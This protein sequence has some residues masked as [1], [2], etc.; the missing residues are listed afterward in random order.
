MLRSSLLAVSAI[1]VAAL[2]YHLAIAI[3]GYMIFSTRMRL[4]DGRLAGFAKSRVY[5]GG[6]KALRLVDLQD[7]V[8]GPLERAVLRLPFGRR[9]LLELAASKI[10]VKIEIALRLISSICTISFFAGWLFLG[11]LVSGVTLSLGVAVGIRAWLKRKEA[12]KKKRLQDQLPNA[13]GLIGNA[14]SSGASLVQALE[15]GVRESW[16]PIS[17]ELRSVVAEV[18]VGVG[19]D[20]AL[21]GLNERLSI[22][23]LESIIAALTIQRRA[24]GNLS[25]LLMNAN[26]MLKERVRV[27]G[28]L[29]A[30]TAQARFSGKVVGLLPVIII[31]IIFLIDPNYL[32]PLFET[33]SGL[34]L[35]GLAAIAELSGFAIIN[36]LLKID[37]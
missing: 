19:L 27:K 37:F 7:E 3:C 5:A 21:N 2:A 9:F 25:E 36:R 33:T 29:M 26:E 17:E 16:P 13:L 10:R 22:T 8:K 34:F 1:S 35:L 32:A 20:D 30:E 15:H 18:G 31:G 28:Q 14:L 11:S 24:G 23:E 4:V 6:H 12:E